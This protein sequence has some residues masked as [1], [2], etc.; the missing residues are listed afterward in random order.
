MRQF[1]INA[2]GS[3]FFAVK[4]SSRWLKQ[5]RTSNPYIVEIAD[6]DDVEV[7]IEA[8]SL[9]YC[10]DLRKKLMKEDVTGVLGIL[11]EYVKFLAESSLYVTQVSLLHWAD[12]T[13]KCVTFQ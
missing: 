9:M 8:L 3:R 13:E 7:Y 6:C 2:M 11:K 12:I 10:K 5:Q 1:K 4:L